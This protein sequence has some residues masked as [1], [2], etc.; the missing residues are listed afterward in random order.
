[1]EL[2]KKLGMQGNQI[3][4]HVMENPKTTIG[5]ITSGA[6]VADKFLFNA[7]NRCSLP[8]TIFTFMFTIVLVNGLVAAVV[9]IDW[10]D[11]AGKFV[12]LLIQFVGLVGTIV[13]T[14]ALI[15]KNFRTNRRKKIS[16]ARSA[17]KR[18]IE[19]NTQ[20]TSQ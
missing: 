5:A 19:V 6:L 15:K 12:G 7:Y 20:D 18:K 17:H 8:I 9:L 16:N 11:I 2:S 13:T 1:M 4:E 3:V 14:L 10:M